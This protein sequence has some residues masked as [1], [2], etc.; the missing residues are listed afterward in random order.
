[1]QDAGIELFV[2]LYHWDLPQ[3]I[4]DATNGGWINESIV[5]FFEL[6]AETDFA[7]FS[8]SVK[9][10]LTFNEPWTFCFLVYETRRRCSL[11]ADASRRTWV[12]PSWQHAAIDATSP[13]PARR[14]PTRSCTR[15]TCTGSSRRSRCRTSSRRTAESLDENNWVACSAAP[16]KE[17]QNMQTAS[18]RPSSCVL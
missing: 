8:D 6:Y 2:T 15:R 17:E 13:A 3:S 7:E 9:Y 1:M 16:C 10:W 12:Q 18:A 11:A 4:Y 14:C 5:D